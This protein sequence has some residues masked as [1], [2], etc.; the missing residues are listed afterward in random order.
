MNEKE[1]FISKKGNGIDM[2][3]ES[4]L[5]I[6]WLQVGVH[7][8]R[9]LIPVG[10]LMVT[11]SC[12]GNRLTNQELHQAYQQAHASTEARACAD[13]ASPNSTI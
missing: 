4:Q 12:A 1:A 2:V 7:Y 8:I 13:C 11:I 10:L 3:T 6:E 9:L 5:S